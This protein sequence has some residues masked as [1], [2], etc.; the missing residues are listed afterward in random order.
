[1]NIKKKKESN[2]CS[3]RFHLKKEQEIEKPLEISANIAAESQ[4]KQNKTKQ[5]NLQMHRSE[6]RFP[7]DS[8]KSSQFLRGW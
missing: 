7:P 6:A 3:I 1:M 2:E 4:P 8:R 5:K